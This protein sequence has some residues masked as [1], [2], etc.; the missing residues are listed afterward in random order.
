M[1][2]SSSSSSSSSKSTS[3]SSRSGDGSDYSFKLSYYPNV[4][5][6]IH[7][8]PI[9]C[10][11]GDLLEEDFKTEL[12]PEWNAPITKVYVYRHDIPIAQ[13]NDL[14]PRT[15]LALPALVVGHV[16]AVRF[17]FHAF[18]IFKT[19]DWWYSAEKC[20]EGLFMQV[21]YLFSRC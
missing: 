14:N 1:S 8:D 19:A 21:P 12:G 15:A 17:L 13:V 16:L 20:E 10:E 3:Q 9:Q 7:K 18:I 2:F 4:D 11:Q 6:K 5:S